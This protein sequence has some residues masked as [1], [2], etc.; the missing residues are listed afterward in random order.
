[1]E[2]Q[3]RYMTSGL[4]EDQYMPGS[5]GKVLKNLLSITTREEIVSALAIVHTEPVWIHPFG[6]F[7]QVKI[8]FSTRTTTI[9]GH[10]PVRLF[11]V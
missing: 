3:V 2:K 7:S 10:I 6:L 11:H 9:F 1:M 8:P 4:V 5:K